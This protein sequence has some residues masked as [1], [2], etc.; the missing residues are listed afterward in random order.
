MNKTLTKIAIPLAIILGAAIIGIFIFI[1]RQKQGN[2]P[3]AVST[4]P[5]ASPTAISQAKSPSPTSSS[6]ASG[7]ATVDDNFAIRLALI[8]KTKITDENLEVTISQNT[9]EFA[10]GTVKNKQDVG[11]GYFLAAKTDGKWIIAYD[12]QSQP[13]CVQIAAYNFPKEMLPECLDSGG[14]VVK[15]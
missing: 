3:Q 8:A 9:G 10:K 6:S 12:G 7:K 14:S 5:T 1:S 4:G 13:T 15:R 2:L 11:G